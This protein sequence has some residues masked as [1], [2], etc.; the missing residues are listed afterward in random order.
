MV[1]EAV[2]V[3]VIGNGDITTIEDAERMFEETHVD[4]IMIGRGLIG[5]PFFLSQLH[6]HFA[7]QEYTEPSYEEKLALCYSYARDLCAYETERI[8]IHQM[9]SIAP[10]FIGGLPFA[11]KYKVKMCNVSSLEELQ[12]V[13]NEYKEVLENL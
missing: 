10:W 9:R 4:A 5:R 13:L 12:G 11:A 7:G 3:P 8:G 2:C 6:A 1:K